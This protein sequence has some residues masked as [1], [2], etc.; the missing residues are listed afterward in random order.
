[1]I[2]ERNFHLHLVSDSTCETVSSVARAAMAQFEA[3]D[4]EEHMWTLVRTERHMEKVI[5]GLQENPGLVLFTLVNEKLQRMLKQACRRLDVPCVPVIS[6]VV[7]AMAQFLQLE[8]H[9]EPGKQYA[10]T[11]EYFSRVEAINFA[12]NH[13]DGQGHWN[14]EEA[15]V[16]IVGVSR[17][18][19]SPTCIYLAYRGIRAANVPFVHGC[20]LP[21]ELE[22]LRR[23]LVVGLTISPERLLQIRRSRLQALNEEQHSDYADREHIV[24]EINE[25]LKYYRTHHW[26]VIDVTRRSVEETSATI[27]QYYQQRQA[28]GEQRA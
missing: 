6:R 16:V 23:P 15:D 11:D 5:A 9:A 13:D 28:E 1:M 8:I 24:E 26:P 25:S 3:V 14:L 27:L 18:S 19:K 4:A 21:E 10:M 7:E 22:R 12:L 2:E 20:P 17:T